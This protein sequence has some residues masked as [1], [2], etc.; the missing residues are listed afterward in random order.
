MFRALLVLI[1]ILIAGCTAQ[2]PLEVDDMTLSIKSPVFV[3][4]GKIPLKYTC[5][6]DNISPP[7][8]IK[9]VPENA[10]SLA[11][12]MEDPDVPKRIRADGIWDHWVAWN[13]PPETTSIKEGSNPEGVIGKNTGGSIGYTGP[14]PPDRQHRYFFK[15]YALDTT[16]NL[17]EGSKKSDVEALTKGHVIEKAEL[18]G[19]YERN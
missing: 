5:D 2:K 1:V 6:G 10:K 13:I 11:L 14:C 4:N 17:P 9:G 7:L 12:I 8:E 3:N 18:V 19:L 16:L 15:L